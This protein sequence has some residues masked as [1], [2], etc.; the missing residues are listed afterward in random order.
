MPSGGAVLLVTPH[1]YTTDT[2]PGFKSLVGPAA[3]VLFLSGENSG[4]DQVAEVFSR[5]FPLKR[6]FIR[7]TAKASE[8]A[9]RYPAGPFWTDSTVRRSF[10]K[11]DYLTQPH[12][13]CM[14]TFPAVVSPTPPQSKA[15][16]SWRKATGWIASLL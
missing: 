15:W 14:G 12:H 3:E 11:V 6:Q 13:E 4:R 1:L 9:R 8:P 16:L 5:M 10:T 2:V 7:E